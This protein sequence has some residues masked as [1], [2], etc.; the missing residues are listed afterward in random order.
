MPPEL[1]ATERALRELQRRGAGGQTAERALQPL[2]PEGFVIQEVRER[3]GLVTGV[4]VVRAATGPPD[5]LAAELPGRGTSPYTVTV[6][7]STAS[8]SQLRTGSTDYPGSIRELYIPLPIDLPQ[9]V[10]QLARELTAQATNPY[11]KAEAA[12][13]GERTGEV[14]EGYD[15]WL[16]AEKQRAALEQR[17]RKASISQRRAGTGILRGDDGFV[18]H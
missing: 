9:R 14:R 2:L 1:E 4:D 10:H 6:S 15:I 13:L 16:S 18:V 3:N 8:K 5:V 17:I 7:I 11:D 12:F